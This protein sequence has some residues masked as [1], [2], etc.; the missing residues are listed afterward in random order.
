MPFFFLNS[1]CHPDQ[2]V[3]SQP[4][5]VPISKLLR[6]TAVVNKATANLRLN[7]FYKKYLNADGLLIVSS[8]NVPDEAL[9]QA[10]MIILQMLAKIS[11]VK[12]KL[13]AN[14]IKVA[15]M[16]INEVTTDIPE[17]SD[18][19]TAFPETNWNTRT[20]GLG[21]T[22]ARPVVSCAEENLL[23]YAR[24]NYR[25]E[26]IL[27]H[28]FAHTIHLMGL[29]YLDNDFDNKLK[30][31]Y[32][33]ARKNGLWENTYA[34]SNYQEYFAE[35]VQCWFNANLEAIPCNGVHNQINTKTELNNYD[36]KLFELISLYFNDDPKKVS[37]QSA[38]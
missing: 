37:R 30:S 22:V 23:G 25:G 33:D 28:E 21:A 17:H 35:G 8:S 6:D 38:K 9:L 15:V 34:I 11:A 18:L 5:P 32:N 20:R 31:I 2:E 29:N 27:I 26:D 19:N 16:G 24:D 1:F 10:R 7:A 4:T 36:P 14:K 12:N 3:R 13:I